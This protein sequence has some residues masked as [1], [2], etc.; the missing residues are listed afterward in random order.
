MF[1]DYINLV[2][3][4]F[5]KVKQIILNYTKSTTG[6]TLIESIRQHIT[7][8]NGKMLRPLL[9]LLFSKLFNLHNKDNITLA[10]VI[11]LIHM[12]TLLHDDVLDN[13]NMRHNKTTVNVVWGNQ[14]AILTGDFL[15][16]RAFQLIGQLENQHKS[17]IFSLIADTANIMVE[18]EMLQLSEKYNFAITEENYL[19]IINYK[20][21]KLFAATVQLPSMTTATQF[22]NNNIN[23]ILNFGLN[24]GMF[25]QLLNDIEDYYKSGNDIAEGR[26][27]LPVIFVLN[28]LINMPLK[29]KLI[30]LIKNYANNAR[31]KQLEH[32]ELIKNTIIN[33]DGFEYTMTIARQYLDKAKKSIIMIT[34]FN[35]F[36]GSKYKQ[37]ILRMVDDL[38]SSSSNVIYKC[39]N[40]G[41]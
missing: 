41:V 27:T 19:K 23:N 4:D 2:A 26:I 1:V 36:N 20:T 29:Q 6:S 8:N 16:S 22:S 37:A 18:G 39:I 9:L 5:N 14:S 38:L 10:A 24:F 30:N 33:H 12:A 34:D 28:N 35:E 31:Y 32:L 11:E 15:Y 40:Y 17:Q 21:A 7:A 13:G 25:Y 3:D